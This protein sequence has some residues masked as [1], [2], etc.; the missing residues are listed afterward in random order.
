ML[1]FI[2]SFVFLSFVMAHIVPNLLLARLR[3]MP[4]PIQREPPEP[5]AS[6]K[7]V[8]DDGTYHPT[9]FDVVV[10]RIMLS[11]SVKLPPDLVDAIFDFA[12][13]WARSTNVIDYQ[14]EQQE[15]LR[16]SGSSA[17]ENK[18]L[19]MIILSHHPLVGLETLT[20]IPAASFLS[21][22]ANRHRRT[23]HFVQGAGLR[24]P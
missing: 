13:Y 5:Q 20:W 17:S 4:L 14:A 18:F 7:S 23:R 1:D 22:R 10:V 16:I 21:S 11:R 15:P 9:P 19:V 3:Q 2:V 8:A 6:N 24:Y 12:E